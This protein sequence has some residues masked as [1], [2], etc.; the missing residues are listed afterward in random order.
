MFQVIEVSLADAWRF[1]Q[2]KRSSEFEVSFNLKGFDYLWIL[3]A[4]PWNPGDRILDVG[5]G[6]SRFPIYMA[7]HYGCEVWAVDDFGLSSGDEYWTRGKAPQEHFQKYPKVKFLLERLG[8]QEQSSLPVNYFDCIYSA[9]TLEHVPPEMIGR[10]WQHM[11]AL[12]K[13]GGDLLHAVEMRLPTQRGVVSLF[14]AFILDYLGFLVP[15][16]YRL[17]NAFF[18]PKSYIGHV[19]RGL[20]AHIPSPASQVGPL[21][22]A[23]DPGVVLEPIDWAYNRMVKDGSNRVTI[24]RMTSLLLHLKKAGQ[25]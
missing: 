3:N 19:R 13:P 4:R 6:Y 9:S 12:L 22:M 15:P 16:G 20:D 24:T 7:D 18:T 5:C 25:D 17:A 11:D 14:K 2:F 21:K 8:D 10:V 23:L 1:L